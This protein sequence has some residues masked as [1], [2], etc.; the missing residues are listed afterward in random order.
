MKSKNDIFIS[1]AHIDDEALIAGESGWISEFH[2]SLEVRLG[3]LLGYRP[4]IWRD[5]KLDG[6]HVFSDE[7]LQQLSEIALL[8]SVHSPRYVKSDWCVRE[9]T[10][11]YKI[12]ENNIGATIGTRSR[13]FKVIKTPVDL[14]LQPPIIQGLL[15][16]EFF[17]IDPIDLI[18][19]EIIKP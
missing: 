16:Y 10:E 12:A 1:Y 8:V 4:N 11:F 18:L 17:K 2:R 5:K 14:S 3:Q 9:L 7:I 6:N 19:I 15:G 13:I